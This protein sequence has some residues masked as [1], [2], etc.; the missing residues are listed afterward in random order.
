MAAHHLSGAGGRRQ[1]A[2]RLLTAVLSCVA[3]ILGGAPVTAAASP[4]AVLTFDEHQ[5]LSSRPI[6]STETFDEFASPTNFPPNRHRVVIDAVRF[7]S[8]D[9]AAPYWAVEREEFAVPTNALFRRFAEGFELSADLA[10]AFRDGGS[11][12]ALGFRLFPFGTPNSFEL[13]VTEADGT[14]TSFALP[15]DISAP[16]FVGLSSPNR[17]TRVLIRQRGDG[18]GGGIS[19]FSLDD[20]SRGAIGR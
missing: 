6:V 14:S 11:V 17:I 4:G 20:V 9:A 1:L 15:T 19:N 8:V 5:F 16:Q 13:V 2:V 3:L 18:T 12:R 10:V 7:R